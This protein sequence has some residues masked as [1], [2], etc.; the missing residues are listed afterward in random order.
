M[1]RRR[2]FIW[3]DKI[4]LLM[5]LFIAG[6]AVLFWA[7]GVAGLEGR[8]HP[9]LDSAMI[10]WTINAE[11]MLVPPIW[12]SLRVLDFGARALARWLRS[13]LRRISGGL[14]VPAYRGGEIVSA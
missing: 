6:S 7:V 10:D 14:R 11:L 12:L 5:V 9:R 2:R 13:S 4:A 3:A 8:P 1:A